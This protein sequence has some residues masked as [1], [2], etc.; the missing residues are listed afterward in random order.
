MAS[1]SSRPCDSA[2]VVRA[3][4]LSLALLVACDRER[5][6][7]VDRV[8]RDYAVTLR[9]G[10]VVVPTE[11][12]RDRLRARFTAASDAPIALSASGP[13]G[14][15]QIPLDRLE[16]GGENEEY[17]PQGA[18]EPRRVLVDTREARGR[19]LAIGALTLDVPA[20]A[21]R[22]VSVPVATC[23]DGDLI[24]MGGEPIGRVPPDPRADVLVDLD[25]SHCYR[26]DAEELVPVLRVADPEV[27]EPTTTHLA[28]A[29][30]HDLTPIH[31]DFPFASIPDR[32]DPDALGHFDDRTVFT[33]LTSEDCPAP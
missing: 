23:A 20:G 16:L 24:R 7:L 15:V 21:R 26:V 25:G 11:W 8:P 28:R 14:P 27:A 10:G 33:S 9:V 30:V 6:V 13:C 17:V 29:H 32:V 31:V 4:L 1:L 22:A 3:V 2:P 19:A 12:R 5:T 18:I